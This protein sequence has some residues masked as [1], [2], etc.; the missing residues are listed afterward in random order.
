M[1]D[2][3]VRTA[4]EEQMND[5]YIKLEGIPPSVNHYVKHTRSGRHYT[6]GEA[7]GFKD[8][9]ALELRDKFTTGTRFEVVL[10]ITLGKK[11][12][13]DVDNFPKLILDGLAAA[14]A[15]RD[16]KGKRVSDARVRRLEISVN[17]RDRP[18]VGLTEI[19]AKGTL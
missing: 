16:K 11:E 5:L 15:F 1:T 13:G 9:I 3:E 12:K 19:W 4:W 7:Q 6:T 10:T 18:D 8:S 14:G 2:F 17:D